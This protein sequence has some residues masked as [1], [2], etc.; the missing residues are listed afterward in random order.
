MTRIAPLDYL[1]SQP[2]RRCISPIVAAVT[3]NIESGTLKAR[4][5]ACH[6]AGNILRNPNFPIG[7]ADNNRWTVPFYEALMKSLKQCKNFK[8]R[9][10]ACAAL[11]T[12]TQKSQYGTSAMF[13]KVINSVREC[14]Q[15]IDQ[16][17]PDISFMEMRYK[18]QLKEQVREIEIYEFG[19][20]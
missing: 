4:W 11:G 20:C 17:L 10:H 12:P 19:G 2:G 3:K 18:E 14:L 6:A 15:E 16:D 13:A 7:S 1:A 5:N 9:I 8:V